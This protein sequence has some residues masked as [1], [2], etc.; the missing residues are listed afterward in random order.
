M[1]GH[2]LGFILHEMDAGADCVI[3]VFVYNVGAFVLS[4][5]F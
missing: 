2:L 5:L 3:P 1:L 4:I